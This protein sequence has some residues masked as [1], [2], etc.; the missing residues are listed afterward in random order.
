MEIQIKKM[1]CHHLIL[2]PADGGG[3][4]LTSAYNYLSSLLL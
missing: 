1:Q 3:G 2:T 4:P